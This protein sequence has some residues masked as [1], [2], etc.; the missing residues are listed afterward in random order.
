MA[1]ERAA[2]LFGCYRKGDAADP[3]IYTAAIAA[4][5]SRYPAEVVVTVTD[6]RTGLPSRCQWLPTVKEVR[7]ACEAEMEPVRAAE[8]REWIE[9]QQEH[10]REEDRQLAADRARRPTLDELRAKY[11]PN[12][13]LSSGTTRDEAEAAAQRRREEM[14]RA[15][16]RIRAREKARSE[17]VS[18][19][20]PT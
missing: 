6:P 9:R 18:R 17:A 5:L 8:R 4:V 12:W 2:I 15:N 3:E 11:G 7:D 16:D 10:R 20:E 19:H 13:G 1:T 14:Q